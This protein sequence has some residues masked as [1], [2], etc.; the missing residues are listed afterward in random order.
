M[1][2]EEF[3]HA[4]EE[5]RLRG[6]KTALAD[7]A[8]AQTEE[9]P[10]EGPAEVRRFRFRHAPGM[11]GILFEAAERPCATYPGDLPFLPAVRCGVTTM[12]AEQRSLQWFGADLERHV[13]SILEQ[14]HAAGWEEAPGLRFPTAS[15][16]RVHILDR[17]DLTRH[18]MA[19]TVRDTSMISLSESPRRRTSPGAE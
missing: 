6:D 11:V 3:A 12:G 14:C 18:V 8:R 19:V 16:A 9:L 7:L 13:A 15:G 4:L 17:G 5:A 2:P 10:P 1:D